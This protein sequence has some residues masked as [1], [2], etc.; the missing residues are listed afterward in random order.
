MKSIPRQA[1]LPVFEV[2]SDQIQIITTPSDFYHQIKEGIRKSNRQ[3]VLASL[4]LGTSEKE[5]VGLLNRQLQKEKGLKVAI[6][7][8]YF[9]GTRL[10]NEGNS[11]ESLLSELVNLYPERISVSFYHSPNGRLY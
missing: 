5:I 2:D 11:S 1:E 4:Y 10:D 9:R 7:L 3:I 8:D 6:L